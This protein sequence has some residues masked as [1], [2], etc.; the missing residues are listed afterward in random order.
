[1]CRG[2]QGLMAAESQEGR[3]FLS[4]L[5]HTGIE[6]TELSREAITAMMCVAK[7]MLKVCLRTETC[8]C[9]M[10]RLLAPARAAS[11]P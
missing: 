1:M 11:A 2:V 5:R 8:T 9:S 4:S 7:A 10:P 6:W 3:W